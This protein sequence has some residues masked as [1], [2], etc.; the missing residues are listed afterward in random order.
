M[1]F[2]YVFQQVDLPFC[3]GR[4]IFFSSPIQMPWSKWMW[5]RLKMGHNFSNT[6]KMTT[7]TPHLSKAFKCLVIDL[8]TYLESQPTIYFSM[9]WSWNYS[10]QTIFDLSNITL[11][12]SQ[13]FNPQS[14]IGKVLGVPLFHFHSIP[15]LFGWN[16]KISWRQDKKKWTKIKFHFLLSYTSLDCKFKI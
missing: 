2:S 6:K 3:V 7:N 1:F 8:S 5:V 4:H 12:I 13:S 11:N 14:G 15:N 10:I 9:Q 16:S